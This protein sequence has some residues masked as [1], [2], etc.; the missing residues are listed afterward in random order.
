MVQ[1]TVSDGALLEAL[2]DYDSDKGV[3]RHL[4]EICS[5]LK[6]LIDDDKI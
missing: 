3:S 1:N 6:N 4:P 5:R 2:F